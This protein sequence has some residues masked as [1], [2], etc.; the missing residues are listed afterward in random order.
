[1]KTVALEV[2]PYGI[3]CN[4]VCPGAVATDMITW[5]G[6]LDLFAGHPDGTREDYVDA[7]YKYH[8]LNGAGPMDPGVIADAVLW[9]AS[10]SARY[11][12]GVALPVEAGH[13]LLPGV[14]HSGGHGG[15]GKREQ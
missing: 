13:L 1:M 7:T 4:A 5:Q 6:A 3:R 2:A 15:A 10:D 11:I 12:T 8:A 9:L 14:N